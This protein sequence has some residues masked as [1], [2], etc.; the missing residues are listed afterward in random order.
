MALKTIYV[1]GAREIESTT[2]RRSKFVRAAL[3]E[4][5]KNTPRKIRIR[6]R[7][8]LRVAIALSDAVPFFLRKI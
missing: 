5:I 6:I 4:F 7:Y 3:E 2:L 1:V 8:I